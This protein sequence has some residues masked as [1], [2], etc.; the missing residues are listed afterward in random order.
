[1][2]AIRA[3]LRLT[4]YPQVGGRG[5]HIAHMLWGGAMMVGAIFALLACL[6]RRAKQ[7]AAALAGVG[8]GFFID[9]LGKFITRDNNY[10][11]RPT[12]GIVYLIFVALYLLS[13]AI[14]RLRPLSRREYL[15]NAVDMVI[16]LLEDGATPEEAARARAYLDRSGA[17]GA[18][19]DGLRETI[20]AAARRE[21]ERPSAR[22]RYWR[23]IRRVYRRWAGRRRFEWLVGAVFAADGIV[24]LLLALGLV[25]ARGL[26]LVQGRDAR[27]DLRRPAVSVLRGPA[28]GARGAGRGLRAA[29][30]REL[31]ARG[32]GRRAPGRRAG[33][34]GRDGDPATLI[35]RRR[36][37]GSRCSHRSPGS[38]RRAT[39]CELDP[40]VPCRQERRHGVRDGPRP[41]PMDRV[42]RAGYLDE[43]RPRRG[44]QQAPRVA[45]RDDRIPAPPDDEGGCREVC[46]GRDRVLLVGQRA[47]AQ[48]AAWPRAQVVPQDDRQEGR[49]LVRRV[50]EQAERL[51]GRRR[52]PRPDGGSYQD[53]PGNA[54]G[55]GAGEGGDHRAAHRMPGEVDRPDEAERV[56]PVAEG[57]R[58]GAD[59]ERAARAGGA[60]ESRQIE[61]VD[62]AIVGEQGLDAAPIGARD[63]QPVHQDERGA[64]CIV[65]DDAIMVADRTMGDPA[66]AQAEPRGVVVHR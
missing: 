52:P 47:G 62:A 8:F 38:L 6:G 24:A 7:F 61:G 55:V 56:Q 39:A 20:G 63:A 57:A 65:A 40:S 33:R 2:L 9:E 64:P 30:V 60:A 19:A 23:A 1:M 34:R 11:F 32:S 36:A 13:R 27:L 43:T 25:A 28:G 22:A 15:V 48:D 17:E 41:T 66:G 5:L 31:P 16:D 12:F 46:D 4:G 42:C 44:P 21:R 37:R 10:F 51:A 18:L 58:Q 26:P 50:A 59:V 49:E 53:E 3:Y 54:V 35:A 45:D 14:A 29:R